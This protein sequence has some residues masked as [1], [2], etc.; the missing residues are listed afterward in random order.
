M[1]NNRTI[2][3]ILLIMCVHQCTGLKRILMFQKLPSSATLEGLGCAIEKHNTERG[4][5]FD[6][7]T[8]ICS[9]LSDAWFTAPTYNTSQN[10]FKIS[11]LQPLFQEVRLA[12]L[13][14]GIS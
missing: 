3:K 6:T 9:G 13:Y 10:Y 4:V 5:R 14:F 2:L 7:Q 8:D 12:N 11:M 1:A